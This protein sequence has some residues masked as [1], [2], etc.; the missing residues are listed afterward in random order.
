MAYF[1]LEREKKWRK[2]QGKG[3]NGEDSRLHAEENMVS[4][5]GL[6][7]HNLEKRRGNEARRSRRPDWIYVIPGTVGIKDKRLL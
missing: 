6:E 2:Q 1:N 5:T 4:L 7:K 3:E